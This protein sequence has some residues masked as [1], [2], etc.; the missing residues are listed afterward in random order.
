M[1]LDFA[2]TY[3]GDLVADM[4]HGKGMNLYFQVVR[5]KNKLFMLMMYIFL[6]FFFFF[7]CLVYVDGFTL[8]LRECSPANVTKETFCLGCLVDLERRNTPLMP[9]GVLRP[10]MKGTLFA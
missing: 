7:F 8:T 9:K 2:L 4:P 10:F 1:H 5:Q 6:T 3:S